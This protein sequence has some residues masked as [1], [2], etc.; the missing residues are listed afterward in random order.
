[1][2]TL[3]AKAGQTLQSA[4]AHFVL[5][6]VLLVS[7]LAFPTTA[8]ASASTQFR[9]VLEIIGP[10]IDK[11]WDT[12]FLV[13]AC[14]TN[15][16]WTVQ[17]SNG[18][19]SVTVTKVKGGWDAASAIDGVV[20]SIDTKFWNNLTFNRVGSCDRPCSYTWN[21]QFHAPNGT[22]TMYTFKARVAMR[23]S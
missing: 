21:V 23:N 18:A 4:W 3:P 15:V 16:T 12:G 5:P 14:H 11:V 2:R 17:H 1:M 22:S 13:G 19:K 20:M 6:F 7:G 10:D 8:H 9:C